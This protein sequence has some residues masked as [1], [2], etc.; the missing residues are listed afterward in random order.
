[1]LFPLTHKSS[2]RLIKNNRFEFSAPKYYDFTSH[3]CQRKGEKE[4]RRKEKE[5]ETAEMYF[6][7]SEKLNGAFSPEV[8][9]FLR[10]GAHIIWSFLRTR[11]DFF[12]ED[13]SH[14]Q[15]DTHSLYYYH[16]TNRV[17][18]AF[19][20]VLKNNRI[21]FPARDESD[22]SEPVGVAAAV[23]VGKRRARDRRS[24]VVHAAEFTAVVARGNESRRGGVRERGRRG[25]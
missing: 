8:L 18:H 13:I 4:K 14:H 11:D 2:H 12:Y 5:T 19:W 24:E 10:K 6:E 16:C 22:E 9:K 3:F 7:T 1:V 21:T 17:F 20:S 23:A 25:E 15:Y